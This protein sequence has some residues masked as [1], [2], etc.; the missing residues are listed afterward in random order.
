[1]VSLTTKLETESQLIILVKA[2][3]RVGG[4]HGELVCCAG[5]D[6]NSNWVRLY[7]VAFRTLEH[8]QQFSRW[9]VVRYQWSLPKGDNRSESRRVAHKSLEIIGH[10]KRREE[11][12]RLLARSVVTGLVAEE[13]AGRS[14]ALLRPRNAKFHW[15]RKSDVVYAKEKQQFT[16]WHSQEE[17]SLFGLLDK[18]LVPYE[19]AEF[20]FRYSYSTDDGDRTGTCQDWEIEATYLKW[21]RKYGSAKALEYMQERF[22]SEY[23]TQGFVLAMGTHKAYGNWLI[24]GVIKLD[25]GAEELAASEPNLI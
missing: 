18:S 7:P 19:P 22:G 13:E 15:V 1:M 9:D 10:V 5:I 20:A 17:N 4:T 23:P 25:H 24:N 16:E 2:A 21:K 14:L 8:T 11:R 12:Q 3:P 6:S